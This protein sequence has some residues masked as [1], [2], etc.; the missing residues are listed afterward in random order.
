MKRTIRPGLISIS[1]WGAAL[2]I[3]VAAWTVC[4]SCG[5]DCEGKSFFAARAV[6][7]PLR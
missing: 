1:L 3:V 4:S 7:S 6:C 2:A 5:A